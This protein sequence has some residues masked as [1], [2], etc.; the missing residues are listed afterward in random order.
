MGWSSGLLFDTIGRLRARRQRALHLR[1]LRLRVLQ[2]EID[3]ARQVER[4]RD[5]RRALLRRR[6]QRLHAGHLRHRVLDAG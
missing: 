2:R 1:D 4:R 3:V 5:A 6:R